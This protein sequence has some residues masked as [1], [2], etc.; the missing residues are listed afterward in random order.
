MGAFIFNLQGLADTF[1]GYGENNFIVLGNDNFLTQQISKV[2]QDRDLREKVSLGENQLWE[3]GFL[4][5]QFITFIQVL[6][7]F[8]VMELVEVKFRQGFCNFVLDTY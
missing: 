7:L 3:K 4:D 8:L 6:F 2:A 5:T 1:R